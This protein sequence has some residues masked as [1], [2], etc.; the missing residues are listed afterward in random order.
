MIPNSIFKI[1]AAM[2]LACALSGRLPYVVHEL[3]I[4]QLELLREMQ[5]KNWGTPWVPR[6]R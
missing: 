5:T 4:A 3:R 1:A 6:G 2:A